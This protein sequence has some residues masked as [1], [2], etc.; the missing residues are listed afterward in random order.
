MTAWCHRNGRFR[1]LFLFRTGQAPSLFLNA[2]VPYL[3]YADE[4]RE[5]NPDVAPEASFR[6]V[7]PVPGG[8]SASP[9]PAFF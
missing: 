6:D 3:Y 9:H 1:G 8:Q 4:A 7:R 5:A 2:H